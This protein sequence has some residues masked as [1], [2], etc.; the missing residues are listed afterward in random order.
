MV[1]RNIATGEEYKNPP[2]Q[3]SIEISE[4]KEVPK[5]ILHQTKT[6]SSKKGDKEFNGMLDSWMIRRGYIRVD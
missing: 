3:V 5:G 4:I 6:I 1:Y 2:E